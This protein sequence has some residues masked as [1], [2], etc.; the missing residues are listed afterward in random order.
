MSNP[1]VGVYGKVPAQ[2]DFVRVNAGELS[3]LGYDRW[4][5][6]AHEVVHG[7][8]GRL[9]EDV[10]YFR[11]RRQARARRSWGRWRPARTRWAG[12]SR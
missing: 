11:W 12:C 10:A 3:R 6:E 1:S 8:R 4:F 9:P 5:Q 2:A 7:E